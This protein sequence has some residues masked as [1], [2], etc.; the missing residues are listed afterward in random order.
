MDYFRTYA[1]PLNIIDNWTISNDTWKLKIMH[2][3]LKSQSIASVKRCFSIAETNWFIMFA[4]IVTVFP[5]TYKK[6]VHI[7]SISIETS[8]R[9]KCWCTV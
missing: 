1:T 3:I 6:Q 8:V 2:I 4:K 7:L 5:Q 9:N